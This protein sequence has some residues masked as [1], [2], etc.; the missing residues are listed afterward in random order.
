MKNLDKGKVEC[1]I[2]VDLQKAF[3][4]VAHNV[5]LAKLEHYGI[6]IL[7]MPLKQFISINGFNSNRVLLKYMEFIRLCTRTN[8]FLIIC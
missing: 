6:F 7:I 1:S 8:S 3:D 5:S 4:M 2:F